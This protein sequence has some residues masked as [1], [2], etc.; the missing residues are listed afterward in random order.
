[1]ARSRYGANALPGGRNASITN[2]SGPHRP[3]PMARSFLGDTANPAGI[4]GVEI[5]ENCYGMPRY[6][7][8]QQVAGANT[9]AAGAAGTVSVLPTVSPYFEP[10]AVYMFGVDPDAFGTNLRFLVGAVTVGGSPQLAINNL[11]PAAAST[12]VLL[13]DVFNRSDEPLLVEWATFS[14]TG[15][16]RELQVSIFNPNAT[17][18]RVYI[19]C[20]GN[21][22]QDITQKTLG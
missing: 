9:I 4:G 13:S 21:A 8:W 5:F 20:W 15:L 11:V 14:T 22:V 6:C 19:V 10:K 3:D 18:V 7:G 17:A 16:A 12:D 2:A 1:M